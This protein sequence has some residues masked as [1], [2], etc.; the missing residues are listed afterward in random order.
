M[1]IKTNLYIKNSGRL[2]TPYPPLACC[3]RTNFVIQPYQTAIVNILWFISL[4]LCI[5]VVDNRKLLYLPNPMILQVPGANCQPPPSMNCFVLLCFQL[6]DCDKLHI[7]FFLQIWYYNDNFVEF[8]FYIVSFLLFKLNF[9]E[10]VFH[11]I[12]TRRVWHLCKGWVLVCD[13][14]L[15]GWDLHI[16]KQLQICKSSPSNRPK[17][18]TRCSSI[19]LAC[20]LEMCGCAC[21]SSVLL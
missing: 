15:L 6:V 12:L 20:G 18:E 21:I 14:F 17:L 16:I 13:E 10:V 2:H 8:F 4:V 11:W 3:Q 9:A 5:S 19:C 7:I 1:T